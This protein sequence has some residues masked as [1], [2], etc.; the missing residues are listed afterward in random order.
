MSAALA[1]LRDALENPI[2]V[3]Q[4]RAA[5]RRRRFAVLLTVLLALL[6]LAVLVTVWSLGRHNDNPGVAGRAAFLTFYGLELLLVLVIFPAVACT[7]IVEE[8]INKS[9]DLLVTTR[10]R[11]RRIILGKLFGALI[12]GLTFL[13]ATAPLIAISFLFGGVRPLQIVGAYASLA[14][15]GLVAASYG[16]LVS[17]IATSAAGAVVRTFVLLPFVCVCVLLPAGVLVAGGLVD[18]I[19]QTHFVSSATQDLATGDGGLLSAAL[20]WGS[21]LGWIATWVSLFLIVAANQIKPPLADRTTAPRLWFVTA[22]TAWLAVGCLGLRLVETPGSI[23]AAYALAVT[24]GVLG[25][26][27]LAFAADDGG[28]LRRPDRFQGWRRLLTPTAGH[29]ALFVLL[30]AAVAFGALAATGASLPKGTR[31]NLESPGSIL[32]WGAAWGLGFVLTLTQAGVLLSRLARSG[33]L[34][35]IWLIVALAAITLFP[36]MW[37]GLDL[38]TDRGQ[39]YKGYALSPLTALW[40]IYEPP[41]R[42]DRQLVLFGVSGSEIND[43]EAELFARFAVEETPEEERQARREELVDGLVAKGVRVRE[44]STAFYLLLGLALLGANRRVG[45]ESR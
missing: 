39:L 20:V 14:L 28:P 34:A 23:K 45:R 4:L 3:V 10:L 1:R 43:A 41:N 12:Y 11:A 7:A 26:A 27:G 33:K 18:R 44:A 16:V 24:I 5:L 36:A 8:R 25:F 32:S 6:A 21:A 22:A 9:L 37:F 30:C 31:A 29:G 38:R 19:G 15:A 40:S 42:L 35:R 17:T 2:V 13:V